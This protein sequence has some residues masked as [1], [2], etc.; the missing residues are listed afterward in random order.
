MKIVAKSIEG[1]EFFYSKKSAH[2]VPNASASIICKALN[3]AKYKLNDGEVWFVHD[4]DKYDSA[5]EY[6]ET[7]AFSR[8]NGAIRRTTMY[9][10]WM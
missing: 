6:A 4:I 1:Q 9:G 8:R 7:Q 10:G 2:K 5:Y 3:D